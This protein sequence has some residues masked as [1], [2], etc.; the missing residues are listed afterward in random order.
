MKVRDFK[1]FAQ[2]VLQKIEE[3]GFEHS[4]I[5]ESILFVTLYQ[6]KDGPFQT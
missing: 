5:T 1:Q 4:L 6:D 2:D 3:L